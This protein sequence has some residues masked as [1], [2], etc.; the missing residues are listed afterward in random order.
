MAETKLGIKESKEALLAILEIAEVLGPILRDGFQAGEDLGKLVAAFASNE[1]LKS[2][3]G[4][5]IDKADQIP[6]EMGDIDLSEGIELLITAAPEL[7]KILEAWK[8]PDVI[9]DPQP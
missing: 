2:K 5:A 4:A 1:E 8:K 9:V 3:L 6:A 7:P